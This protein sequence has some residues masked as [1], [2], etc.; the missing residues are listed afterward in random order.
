MADRRRIAGHLA[1]RLLAVPWNA[2]ALTGEMLSVVDAKRSK[3]RRDRCARIVADI[4]DLPRT[5][6]PSPDALVEMLVWHRHFD[7]AARKLLQA[8]WLSKPPLTSARF[9]PAPRFADLDVPRIATPGELAEWLGLSIEELDWFSG[10]RQP[11]DQTMIPVLQHYTYVF[12]PKKS[13][14]PRLI[15]SPKPRLK[16]MQRRILDE[17]LAD[18]PAHDAAHGFVRGRSALTGAQVHASEAMVVAADLADFFPSTPLRRVHGIF[19]CLGYPWA[20]ARALTGL[21]S[22]STPE[23]VFTRRPLSEGHSFA[24]RKLHAAR[25]LPQGAPTSPAL[26]NLCAYGLDVRLAG[27]ARASG[28]AYTRY[29][30]DLTFSGDAVFGGRAARVLAAVGRIAQEE[31]YRLN[32][33]KTRVMPSHQRQTVTGIVV[34]AH[35]NTARD[36][37]DALKALLH[38]CV[39][40]GPETQNREAGADFSAHLD[41]RVHWVEQVNPQRGAKLRRLYEA[42]A[43]C[44]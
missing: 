3:V 21:V 1:A 30:D 43:W 12:I 27:L 40:F 44:G 34:N 33:G 29:A 4:L 28:A 10:A 24:K 16:T 37:F 9:Q 14:A 17:M 35:N 18:V 25:H 23:A 15:E 7:F 11:Y 41:G 36:D 38:N 5:T 42:I 32:V 8:P 2:T 13:G 20:V 31:G 6:P 39:R 22:T 19:R 26:A